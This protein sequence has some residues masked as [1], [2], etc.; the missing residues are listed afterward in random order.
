MGLDGPHW[1]A[2]L[3]PPHFTVLDLLEGPRIAGPTPLGPSPPL[4]LASEKEAWERSRRVQ[5]LY[6]TALREVQ[7][8][9]GQNRRERLLE[10]IVRE[11]EV[12]EADLNDEGHSDAASSRPQGE[13]E[14]E[15]EERCIWNPQDLCT[16]RKAVRELE[17]DR[18]RLRVELKQARAEAEK[19][20]EARRQLQGLLDEREEQLGRVKRAATRQALHLDALCAE[21]HRRDVQLEV[22]A[23]E[24]K[25]RG[26]EAR[27]AGTRLRKAEEV[28]QAVRR[29]NADL[30]WELERLRGQQGEEGRRQAQAAQVECEAALWGL[31][32]EAETARAELEAE[33]QSH[34][35]SRAALEL[36]RKHFSSQSPR[37]TKVSGTDRIS[38]I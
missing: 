2:K 11:G 17:L 31:R 22:Q 4:Q 15:K 25:D 24:A 14:E 19:Q 9:E 5:G 6:R 23:T 18:R 29:E 36:L 20:R 13:K 27:A 26:E 16:L 8:R 34:T 1:V 32:R 7:L 3:F 38:Y 28:A 12:K 35:R 30:A 37:D 33:R 10:M 21:G